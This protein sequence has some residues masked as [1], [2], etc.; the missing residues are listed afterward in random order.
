MRILLIGGNGFIGTPLARELSAAGHAVAIFHR[1]TASSSDGFV[2]IQGDR[3]QLDDYLGKIRTFS[4]QVIIDVILS[5]GQQAQQLADVARDLNARLVAIS[6]MDVYRAAGILQGTESG[7]LEPPMLTE[8]STLSTVR[9]VYPAELVEKMKRTYPWLTADYSKVA[10]EEAVMRGGAEN[11]VLRL[12]FGYGPEDRLHRLWGVLKRVWDGR[13]AILLPDDHAAWRG[14]RGYVEN[15]A[16]AIALACTSERARGRI[17]H[18][19]DEPTLTELEWQEK[20]AEQAHWQGRFVVLP[21]AQTPKHLLMPGNP[22]QHLIADCGRIRRELGYEQPVSTE[23]AIRRTIEWELRNPPA[24]P[25]FAQFDYAAED[26]ALTG[27]D[28]TA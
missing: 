7:E 25:L 12:P 28:P 4:P 17:Y 14:P 13:P 23:E 2:H 24:Q 10:V 19:C 27:L 9:R 8:D 6:S 3:H 5:S 22:A 20:I 18:V 16:H 26:A 15:M 21:R 1:G 11:S